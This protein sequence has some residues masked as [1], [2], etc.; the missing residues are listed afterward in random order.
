MSRNRLTP[1]TPV[2]NADRARLQGLVYRHCNGAELNNQ[3]CTSMDAT[4]HVYLVLWRND[5]EWGTHRACLSPDIGGD[6][7][8]VWGHFFRGP[9]AVVEANKDFMARIATGI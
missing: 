8:L 5:H 4:E 7:M 6:M 1:R 3:Y 9:N 2:P